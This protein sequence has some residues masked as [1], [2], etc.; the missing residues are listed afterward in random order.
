[1]G[2]TGIL[3]RHLEMI[4]VRHGG[5]EFPLE[6]AIAPI[7]SDGAPM[8][9]AY[10]RDITQRKRAERELAHHTRQLQQSRDAERQNARQLAALV[11]ELR[12]AH[13]HSAAA[14]VTADE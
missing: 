11:D 2:D 5:E 10:M 12:V 3:N 6:V 4:A 13:T 7:S 1:M 9:A 8:F 14:V